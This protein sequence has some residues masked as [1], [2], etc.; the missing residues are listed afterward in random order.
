MIFIKGD[1][2][3][4]KRNENEN[5]LYVASQEFTNCFFGKFVF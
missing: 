3:K 5:H 2:K 1:I 4:K